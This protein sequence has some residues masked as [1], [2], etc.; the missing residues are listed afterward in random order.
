MSTTSATQ[1]CS[2]LSAA[3]DPS[4]LSP[5]SFAVVFRRCLSPLSFAV[6][7]RRCLSPLSFAV[8][9]SGAPPLRF[10]K[11][12]GFLLTRRFFFA[13]ILSAAKNLS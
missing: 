9:F 4:C 13:V 12:W 11:G 3:K 6:V 5:L 2:I 1:F 7:F 8:A 10:Y